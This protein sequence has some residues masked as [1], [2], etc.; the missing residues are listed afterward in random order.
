[1]IRKALLVIVA[2]LAA[3][4]GVLVVRTLGFSSKQVEVEPVAAIAVDAGSVA[5]HLGG[6]LR[7]RTISHQDS[8]PFEPY[9]FIDFHAYLSETFPNVQATLEREVIAG[10]SLLYRW[11]G[12]DPQL[13]S[14]LLM[15]HIDVVPVEPGTESDWQYPAYEGRVAEGYVW[16]R[17]TLDDKGSLIGILEAVEILAAEGFQ[18]RRTVYLAFGHDEEVGGSGARAIAELLEERGIELE[19]VLDEGGLVTDGVPGI[20]QSVALVGIAEKG[21]ITLELTVR[22]EGGHSSMPP[23]Q[24]AVGIL[25]AAIHELETHPIPGG[26]RGA[27]AAM[28]D[29][30]GPE[31]PFVQRLVV[32]NR[33]LLGPLIEHQF[34][35]SPEG[36]SMLRTTTA[37]TIFRAGVKANV[38]PASAR[39]AVNFRIMPGDSAG[40]VIE[41]VRRT[42]DDPR[43]EITPP[44]SSTNPSPVS[45]IESETF[46][47]LQQ[48]IRQIFPHA[49]VAPYLVVG[50]TDSRYFV[51]LT[52]NVYRFAPVELSSGEYNTVHGTDERLAVDALADM[53]RFYVQLI[54]NSA[55]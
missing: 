3:L 15:A 52:R 22:Q 47:Q 23:P 20:D 35:A 11:P 39:A 33:W 6:A 17:G 9:P 37:A 32:A 29:Y 43:V 13:S 31:M 28:F 26:I 44:E 30:L 7:F 45:D 42:I 54:R 2:A 12:S 25:S 48:T 40:T 46:T 4:V 49:V 38:L 21:F 36:N 41:H 19:F 8:A 16:G 1:M 51:S 50:G 24:T 18:P 14:I 27:S 10:Y 55:S 34:G 5:E 53:V